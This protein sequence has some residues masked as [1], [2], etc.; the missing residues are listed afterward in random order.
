MLYFG[1]FVIEIQPTF[2]VTVIARETHIL[3]APRGGI[4][5]TAPDQLNSV[6]S[7]DSPDSFV[8]DPAAH[9]GVV[10]LTVANLA[11][12]L[13]FYSNALGFTVLDRTERDAVLA[14]AGTPLLLLHEQPGALPWMID[15]AT[16]LYH[17]AI[18]LP[19]RAD[20]GRWL[21]QY[22]TTSFP[23]PGQ[24]DHIVSEALYLRDPDG[25]GIEVYADRPRE[26][27]RWVD[28]RVQMGGGPVDLR[29]ILADGTAKPWTGLLPAGTKIG[30]IH[31]QVGDIAAAEAFYHGILGFAVT[32]QIPQ[33][34]LFVSAGGYHHHIGM[35]TWHSEGAG[36]AP[37]DTAQL[38]FYTLD[39]PSQEARDA[40][41]ASIQAAGLDATRPRQS[42]DVVIVRDPWQ[43]VIVLQAGAAD[44]AQTAQALTAAFSSASEK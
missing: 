9:V 19:T 6:T 31:L 32:A 42:N 43:N 33:A 4:A 23:P 3:H 26:G 35:N 11:R 29:G 7:S 10:A 36:P 24:G 22:L 21:R 41:V 12:S 20:L 38:R 34:A 13:A 37:D 25:H 1:K 17:F 5:M 40:V 16:G 44:D 2:T 27:W 8:I 18:L 30:H 28:G 39:L 14:V 15:A